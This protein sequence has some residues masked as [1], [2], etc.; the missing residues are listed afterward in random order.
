M[1][2]YYDRPP[3]LLPANTEQQDAYWL[4]RSRL[5]QALA[6]DWQ[7]VLEASPATLHAQASLDALLTRHPRSAFRIFKP[8]DAGLTVTDGA[9][10]SS[11]P[12]LR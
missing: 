11:A 6:R 2:E 1:R 10:V 12:F 3:K 7:R 9:V 4:L 8:E 5:T